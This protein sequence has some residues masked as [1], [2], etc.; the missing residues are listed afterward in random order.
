VGGWKSTLIEVEERGGG[1][2]VFLKG[3]LRRGITFDM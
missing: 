2:G 3:K 1:I